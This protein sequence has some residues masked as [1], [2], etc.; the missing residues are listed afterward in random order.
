MNWVGRGDHDI[1][2]W[3]ARRQALR[4]DDHIS[5]KFLG[6]GSRQTP[7]PHIGPQ[8]CGSAHRVGG[9]R[10]VS[11]GRHGVEEIQTLD[12]CE[13]IQ[14][15]QLSSHLVICNLW[16]E[17]QIAGEKMVRRPYPAVVCELQPASLHEE[18]E[19]TGIKDDEL[20]HG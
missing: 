14:A 4:C 2:Y 10:E 17:N 7:L 11:A 18:T 19:W 13:L 3:Q 1:A 16:N 20:T 12:R 15:K 5:I 8:L 6:I 9:K